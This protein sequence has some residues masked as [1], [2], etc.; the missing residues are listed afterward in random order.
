MAAAGTVSQNTPNGDI[1]AGTNFFY[2]YGTVA[3]TG[4]YSTGGDVL[5]LTALTYALGDYKVSGTKLPVQVSF[6]S[7]N[8][9]GLGWVAG[10]TRA[11]GKIFI[12][13][14][15]NTQLSAGAYPAGLTGD[16][17]TFCAIF[18]KA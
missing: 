13:T 10:T 1:E 6:V 17:I 4:S 7:K 8:G 14:A 16:V 18:P 12:T 5:D 15:S 3:L 9:Y 11:N 2:V